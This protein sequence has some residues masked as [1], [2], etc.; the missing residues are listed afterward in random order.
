[1]KEPSRRKSWQP[2]APQK[3]TNF[4]NL[5]SEG[6]KVTSGFPDHHG[7]MAPRINMTTADVPMKVIIGLD[8]GTTFT[9]VSYGIVP[10]EEVNT[11][12]F[13]KKYHERGQLASR[14]A[15]W[16]TKAAPKRELDPP[17]LD[18][19]STNIKSEP[20]QDLDNVSVYS[21]SSYVFDMEQIGSANIERSVNGLS[22]E[23]M[24]R[25]KI[26][27]AGIAHGVS[28]QP[29]EVAD[30]KG[31]VDDTSDEEVEGIHSNLN[32][33]LAEGDRDNTNNV[34]KSG[35]EHGE[36]EQMY[37]LTA[38]P[39]YLLRHRLLCMKEVIGQDLK[40]D[41]V[42]AAKMDHLFEKGICGIVREFGKMFDELEDEIEVH[43]KLQEQATT[44]YCIQRSRNDNLNAEITEIK[45][46]REKKSTADTKLRE[47][48]Q[49]QNNALK[50]AYG[51]I[52]SASKKNQEK[53]EALERKLVLA[54]EQNLKVHDAYINEKTQVTKL[55]SQW[56]E[57]REKLMNGMKVH[58]EEL[59]YGHTGPAMYATRL[60]RD[61]TEWCQKNAGADPEELTLL[62]TRLAVRARTGCSLEDETAENAKDCR[63]SFTRQQLK[64]KAM[65]LLAEVEEMKMEAERR[66]E[67]SDGK[68]KGLPPSCAQRQSDSFE[69]DASKH[70]FAYRFDEDECDSK[71]IIKAV[72]HQARSI[73]EQAKEFESIADAQNK[74]Q[75]KQAELEARERCLRVTCEI[76]EA[77]I[78]KLEA[79][80]ADEVYNY[81]L[82]ITKYD[83]RER[84]ASY[85][86]E[87]LANKLR[88]AAG[89]IC[90]LE[91]Q[92]STTTPGNLN[93]V[94][95]LGS[96]N[97][98]E[99]TEDGLSIAEYVSSM[100]NMVENSEAML[101]KTKDAIHD[102][103]RV[104][105]RM[106]LR[107][108]PVPS[109]RPARFDSLATLG[110]IEEIIL[111]RRRM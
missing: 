110:R 108:Q 94:N 76:K 51:H 44:K 6:A 34:A 64:A 5:S 19:S 83:N 24:E 28:E 101:S 45:A 104:A 99:C 62:L 97:L 103:H 42:A 32:D 14:W 52:Q 105:E 18:E 91:K 57:F 58:F 21:D 86:I 35:T 7:P 13:S 74:A 43:K 68:V 20:A 55:M 9:S 73:T 3:A 15:N 89:Q 47:T 84:V 26:E 88:E 8:Y 23:L 22:T 77:R 41:P 66:M 80:K 36:D 30:R 100:Q 93:H 11:R 78:R 92:L 106:T 98:L 40:L 33:V 12:P 81:N 2:A 27:S 107:P 60:I 90:R 4:R 1:M 50:L 63:N 17:S 39:S 70:K 37:A 72:E 29:I 82:T 69:R 46:K 61:I 102:L 10:V 75:F 49:K 38:D 54:Q 67:S 25:E 59:S 31:G 96:P 56:I 87:T 85:Q 53:T 65:S 111:E 71:Y 16:R 79:E 109:V 95:A 48:L